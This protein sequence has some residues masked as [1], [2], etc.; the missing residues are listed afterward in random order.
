MNASPL[1]LA[2]IELL[3]ILRLPGTFIR[4]HGYRH[5]SEAVRG[6][7]EV[8]GPGAEAKGM[9]Y[10]GGLLP[11]YTM[12]R[13]IRLQVLHPLDA[14][15]ATPFKAGGPPY[16]DYRRT[17]RRIDQEQ[18]AVHGP[19]SLEPN[20]AATAAYHSICHPGTKHRIVG[21]AVI[22]PDEDFA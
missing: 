9:H 6:R 5:P 20:D 15:N 19:D 16:R 2:D 10:R 11:S 14:T 17:N 8:M 1:T 21:I 18:E 22:V 3:A 12:R 13:L 4:W 7:G